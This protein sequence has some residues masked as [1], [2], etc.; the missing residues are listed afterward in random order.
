MSM[1]LVYPHS[2]EQPPHGLCVPY[3][4]GSLLEGEHPVS[5]SSVSHHVKE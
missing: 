1:G 2:K 5:V 4:R 3:V